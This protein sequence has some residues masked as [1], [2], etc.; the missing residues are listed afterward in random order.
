MHRVHRDPAHEPAF[1][2]E[3]VPYVAPRYFQFGGERNDLCT[4]SLSTYSALGQKQTHA[5]QNRLSPKAD[6]F[7]RLT[8]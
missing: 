4:P 5:V 3:I 6:I 7:H 1:F 2:D 8:F